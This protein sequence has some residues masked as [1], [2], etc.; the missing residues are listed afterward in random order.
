GSANLGPNTGLAMR[1]CTR[2]AI[3]ITIT[4]P[5]ITKARVGSQSPKM[6]RKPRTRSGSVMPEIVRPAPNSRPDS[7]GGTSLRTSAMSASDPLHDE[8]GGD[9][10]RHESGGGDD[11]SLRQA[12]DAAHAVAAC[13]AAAHAGAEADQ[14]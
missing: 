12:A 13:A 5:P 9:A 7:S 11:R 10:G 8:H 6:S 1:A 4:A 2:Q 3:A 14:Q